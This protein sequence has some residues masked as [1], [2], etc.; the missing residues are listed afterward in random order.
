MAL[1]VSTLKNDLVSAFQS[2]NNGD[3]KV[4]SEKVSAAVK[5]FAE[6][7]DIATVDTGTLPAGVYAGAGTGG[8]EAD[9]SACEGIIYA[10][11]AAM[12]GMKSG[13]NEYHAAQLA[14]G[15]HAMILAGEVK[16]DVSGTVTPPGSPPVA[17]NGSA[18][19]TM[20][21]MPS[22]MQASFETAFAA[23]DGMKS[24]G[25]EYMAQQ[26]ASAVDAYLKAAAVNTQGTG[27]LSGSIG[28][29]LMA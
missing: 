23:M 2:M 17:L 21:G 27:P 6:S 5:K 10:A 4:Y 8:I 26:V 24:G 7:G 1:V 28:A 19:G 14:A 16:T 3:N 18:T 22:L 9:D 29:G 11:C 25:D 20:T 13:G 15:I 12:G